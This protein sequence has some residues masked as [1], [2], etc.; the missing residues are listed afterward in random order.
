MRAAAVID[1]PRF[2]SSTAPSSCGSGRVGFRVRVG[3]LA[4]MGFRL[5]LGF[6]RVLAVLARTLDARR[7]SRVA[8][9]RAAE[10]CRTLRRSFLRRLLALDLLDVTALSSD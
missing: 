3:F 10:G 1:R 7:V 6:L 4:R 2:I 8:A 9:F 5:R